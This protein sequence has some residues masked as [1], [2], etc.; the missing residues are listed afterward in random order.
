MVFCTSNFAFKLCS[1][2]THSMETSTESYSKK[3][4]T[5]NLHRACFLFYLLIAALFWE[6]LFP[7]TQWLEK[8][9]SISLCSLELVAAPLK[10]MHIPLGI[11]TRPTI[12]MFKRKL[13]AFRSCHSGESLVMNLTG[14]RII[15]QVD[16]SMFT[17]TEI[18]LIES[19]FS[20]VY[21]R[22][23]YSGLYCFYFW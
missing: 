23:L 18:D 2:E 1:R 7:T 14:Q 6:W 12:T 13:K 9:V 5:V 16:I 4:Y 3:L 21:L 17:I 10:V 15:C 8:N 22:A 11:R 19:Q 20:M